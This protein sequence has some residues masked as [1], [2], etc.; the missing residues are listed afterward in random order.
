MNATEAD[1]YTKV[2]SKRARRGRSGDAASAAEPVCLALLTTAEAANA[3]KLDPPAKKPRVTCSFD[4]SQY[5]GKQ[6]LRSHRYKLLMG[7]LGGDH[8]VPDLGRNDGSFIN[9]AWLK[10]V[11]RQL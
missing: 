8:M 1:G 2:T 6:R 11:A 5:A 7:Q 3:K 10:V 4:R 9:Y